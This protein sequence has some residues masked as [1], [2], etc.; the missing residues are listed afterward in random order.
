MDDSVAAVLLLSKEKVIDSH[1]LGTVLF[2][3]CASNIK[4]SRLPVIH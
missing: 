3:C 4:T 2:V 1:R